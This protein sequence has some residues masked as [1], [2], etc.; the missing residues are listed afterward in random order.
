MFKENKKHVQKQLFSPA[1]VLPERLQKILDKHWSTVFYEKIFCAID[2]KD[3]EP[4]FSGFGRPNFPVNVLVGLEI[5]KELHAISDEQLYERF[6]FDYTYQRA[7]GVE[8]IAEYAFAIRTL[9]YFRAA[10]AEYETKEKTSLYRNIFNSDRDRIIQEIGLKTGIQRTDS[11]MIA[12]NIK[13]MTRVSLFH[14]VFSNLVRELRSKSVNLSQRYTDLLKD[15]EDGF[16]YRLAREKVEQ[17]LTHIGTLMREVLLNHRNGLIGTKAYEDAL[18]LLDEQCIVE[19]GKIRL[20][21]PD[22]IDSG[23][24]QNPSDPDATY[25]KKR[26][27]PHHGFSAHAVETCDPENSIQV[28]THVEIVKNN[29]DDATVLQSAIAEIK[30]STGVEA[31]VTDGGYISSGVRTECD[32]LNIDLVATAIRGHE[33]NENTFTSIDFQIDE[34]GLISICPAGHRPIKRSIEADGTLKATFEKNHCSVCPLRERCIAY[35]SDGHGRITI[36]IHRR[37]LDERA[38]RMGTEAYATLCNLRPPVEGLMEKLKP[39]YLSG[40]T[41]F[42]GLVKV[43]SRMI[44]KGIGLNFRRYHAWFLL[45]LDFLFPPCQEISLNMRYAA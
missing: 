12:A 39:K 40:R 25:R 45:F 21:D 15:D 6:H 30:E 23:S 35:Q 1:N 33:Q 16:S 41:L 28:I 34:K 5:L 43:K 38:A 7:L 26:E 2:E 4:I 8:N 22:D 17:A 42:R 37:W 44:L 11:T 36:D 31:I 29:V 9:Y 32:S 20:K 27:Q 14:K 13:R 18:R 24:L 3:F 10:V 19:S